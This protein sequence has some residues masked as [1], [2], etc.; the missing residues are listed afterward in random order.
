MST[1]NLL[2]QSESKS[3][4]DGSILLMGSIQD[5]DRDTSFNLMGIDQTCSDFG[6]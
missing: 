3:N 1:M 4:N 5:P 2:E 6:N